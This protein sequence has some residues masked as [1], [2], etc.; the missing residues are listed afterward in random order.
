MTLIS[1]S[2]EQTLEIGKKLADIVPFGSI[3]AMSGDLGAG[4][5][6]FAK[7]F[8]EALGYTGRV[9]SPT[10]A[11]AH[12]YETEKCKICH[13]DM[14]R[15]LDEYS[16]YELGFDD[17]LSSGSTL[18]IEWSENIRDFLPT[19]LITVDIR[20]GENE[21]SRIFTIEGVEF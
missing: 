15:I 3:I 19:D 9:T 5:T 18:L 16:L 2:Y 10:F 17:Y 14:Y 12:E 8:I 21:D 13:F 11:I 4:K 1:N 20:H 7:G 6:A